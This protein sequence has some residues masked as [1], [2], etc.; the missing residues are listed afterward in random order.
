MRVA[1]V[2]VIGRLRLGGIMLLGHGRIGLFRVCRVAVNRPTGRRTELGKFESVMGSRRGIGPN[3][4]GI[5]VVTAIIM[6]MIVARSVVV[7]AVI[8]RSVIAPGHRTQQRGSKGLQ[9][10]N[11][12]GRGSRTGAAS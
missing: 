2:F 10:R 3:R 9:R 5:A 4:L 6:R 11:G 7:G 12:W 1:V 8:V